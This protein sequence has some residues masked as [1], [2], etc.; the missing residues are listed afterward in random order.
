M[1][2]ETFLIGFFALLV[3]IIQSPHA[4]ASQ[5]TEVHVDNFPET[6]QIKGSVSIEGPIKHSKYIKKEG[7]LV[8]ISRRGELSEMF[9][10]GIVEVEGFTSIEVN[11]QG[12]IKSSSFTSG[13]IGVL[14]VPD[15]EPV[16]RSLRE[17]KRIQFPIEGVAE[18]KSGDSSF[19]S[20]DQTYKRVTF[21]RYRLYLYNTLNKSAEA[22]VY[23]H[24][25]N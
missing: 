2:K 12:E 1:K 4:I 24:L 23:I 14:L 9:H 18:I 25:S 19:F 16:L 5:P 7:L 17:A 3:M 10:G 15:E 8:P 6:L 11:L 21:P 22:N 20:A 13:S